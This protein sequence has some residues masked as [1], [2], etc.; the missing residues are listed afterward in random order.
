MWASYAR[1]KLISRV[2]LVITI[3]TAVCFGLVIIMAYG[4]NSIVIFP[5]ILM[6][7]FFLISDDSRVNVILFLFPIS[8]FM[9][10]N[11]AF[12]NEEHDLFIFA[13]VIPVFSYIIFALLNLI[14]GLNDMIE[15]A[16]RKSRE[17]KLR[18]I[19]QQKLDKWNKLSKEKQEEIIR[20]RKK[21]ESD[22]KKLSLQY[23][24]K[25]NKIAFELRKQKLDKENEQ[26]KIERQKQIEIQ[27]EETQKLE[28]QKRDEIDRELKKQK[29]VKE[30][31]RRK[32]ERQKQREIKIKEDYKRKI[33]KLKRKRELEQEAVD[34][35]LSQ[36]IISN[37]SSESRKRSAIPEDIKQIVWR[38]DEGKCCYCGSTENLEF[39]HIIPFTKG[40][41]DSVKNL[42]ILCL[43]CNR[44]KSS[45]I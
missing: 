43:S 12:I 9:I 24:K 37:A 39:D 17:R 26:R 20:A 38:R 5:F 45:K 22:G 10:S 19:E 21:E 27:K 28:K 16:F 36:G 33:L 8:I 42:Q 3:W 7:V 11:Y 34:E 30:N 6:L 1:E 2:C 40:G 44:K 31:E 29:L 35:L 15:N 41:S 25:Q 4:Q 32:I 18:N 23:N 13:G 14:F